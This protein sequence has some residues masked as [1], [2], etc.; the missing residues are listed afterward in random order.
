[1]TNSILLA[2]GSRPRCLNCSRE[3][4]PN[5]KWNPVPYCLSTE[6]RKIWK[7]ANPPEFKGT[8]GGYGD[9]RFCGLNCGYHWAVA[10]SRAASASVLVAALL[11]VAGCG[12]Q[13]PAA[14][15]TVATSTITPPPTPAAP[16][17]ACSVN[18]FFNQS[19]ATDAQLL[20]LWQGAQQQLATQ[21]IPMDPV[22]N[23]GNVQYSP[24]DPRALSIEPACKVTV[25]ALPNTQP[26]PTYPPGFPCPPNSDAPPGYYCAG[27]TL[28][29]N[30]GPWTIEVV[31]NDLLDA[32]AT[33]WEM[34]NVILIR[35]GYNVGG[36]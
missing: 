13:Q 11:L 14:I 21:P 17:V 15:P 12:M 18:G 16:A 30:G 36:R 4:R 8:Y 27:A 10:H 5:F 35:L 2:V 34:Q 28:G 19:T 22:T 23:P 6:E 29:G 9:N 32:D 26:L 33:G 1:M 20:A 31:Q 24:P 3:L 7:K 25:I